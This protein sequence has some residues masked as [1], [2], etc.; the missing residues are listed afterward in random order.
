MA[1]VNDDARGVRGVE[2]EA[3]IDSSGRYVVAVIGID[4]YKYWPKL[5]N[6]VQDAVGTAELLVDKFGFTELVPPLL[7]ES[8]TKENIEG[9]VEDKLRRLLKEDDNLLLLFAG[10]GHTRVASVGGSS[11][12]TGYLVP[13]GAGIGVEERWSRYIE[14]DSLLREVATL[15]ARHILVLLDSCHSGFALSGIKDKTRAGLPRYEASLRDKLSRRVVTSARR[16]QEALD[17]GPVAG[18][19]LFTGSLV[20][21]LDQSLADLDDSEFVT[22]SEIGLFL[23]QTVGRYSDSRQT[24]DFGSFDLDDR[25]EMVIPISL[26]ST[27]DALE[28]S[29]FA[30]LRRGELNEVKRMLTEL[31][32]QGV[33]GP[34]SVYLNYRVYVAERNPMAAF[35]A[36]RDLDSREWNEGTIPLSHHDVRQLFFRVRFW[37]V[38][39][40]LPDDDFPLEVAFLTGAEGKEIR[41]E[42]A[43]LSRIGNFN[44]FEI[45]SGSYFMLEISNPTTETWH[46]YMIDVDQDGRI[47]PVPLWKSDTQFDGLSAGRSERTFRFK[48]DGAAPGMSE[49][50][51]FAS[52]HRIRHL[53]SPPSTAARGALSPFSEAEVDGVAVR[54]I[55]YRA[56]PHSLFVKP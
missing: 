24:P 9:L 11:V 8:A 45:E 51:L 19:S 43:E 50:R 54:S 35:L 37:K 48:H 30:A 12:E 33:A 42:S 31:D 32:A 3:N 26:G 16:Y 10:H 39:L 7:N 6:A 20:V 56:V 40:S 25:G 28:R 49:L 38:L 36:I 18:H 41:F 29:A 46:V 15:P 53:L 4:N 5:D 21:G 44:G 13:V 17:S 55:V 23:Q 2:E 22:S 14:I 27:S 52:R 34:K 1:Q 47:N